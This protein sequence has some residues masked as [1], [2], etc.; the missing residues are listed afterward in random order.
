[1][2]DRPE[3]R[4][5]LLW[6]AMGTVCMAMVMAVMLALQMTQ[7]RA[8]RASSELQA[9]SVTALTFQLEREF[10]R[11][12]QTLDNA[13]HTDAPPDPEALTL[14]SDILMS[15]LH[16]MRD[17][18]STTILKDRREYV[19]ALPKL[20]A[21]MTRTT[22]VLATVPLDRR[23]LD[24]LLPEF[25][26]LGPDLQALSVASNSLLSDLL[27]Q[28]VR[29]MLDQND[30]IVWL[31]LAQLV[32]LLAAA[33]T[34]ALRQRRQDQERQKLEEMTREL[35]LANL[36]AQEANR[37]KSQFLANMSHE[38]RTPFNGMLGML[39]LLKDTQL[40]EQQTDFVSTAQASAGHLL[41][42]LNDILDVSAL[43]AGKMR[44]TPAPVHLPSLLMDVEALM[45]PVALEKNLGFTMVLPTELPQW[46]HADGTR[47]K[48]I[49]LN[50]LSNAIKFSSQGT[51]TLT[52][53]AGPAQAAATGLALI[54]L[55]VRVSDQGIGMD[56]QT[57]SRLFQR[58]SQG[59]AST[60]RRFGGT[61][62]GLEISRSL[63]RLMGGDISI[64]S[65]PGQG[66]VFTLALALP[67]S[68]PPAIAGTT[69]EP[70][71]RPA[72]SPGLD[73]LVAEDHPVNRKFME[74]LLKRL[75]HRARFA[76]NGAQAVTEA[77]R[78]V[79]DLILMDLHMPVMDGLQATRA[80]REGSDAA[81]S[82]PIVALTADAFH[83]SRDRTI[84][85]GM[86]GF[87]SKP[88]RTDQIEALLI[89][90]FGQRGATLPPAEST[91]P[92]PIA[93][94]APAPAPRR[95][96][97]AGD[98]GHHLDMSLVGEVCIAVSLS[99]YSNLLESFFR[100]EAQS[101]EQLAQALEAADKA[102]LKGLAHSVK[103]A[104]A[105]LGLQA[106]AQAASHIE[107]S[108]QEFNAGQCLQSRMELRELV[109]TAHAICHRMGLIGTP[110]PP[111]GPA[112][113]PP[114]PA[115]V[116]A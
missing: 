85:A 44:I 27:E 102:G 22:A 30:R 7:N 69:P 45:R 93:R 43:E 75:G 16:L 54:P 66:S 53:E 64:E 82:V 109:H 72:G 77:R 111:G 13:V 24:R 78:V 49:V 58:F 106:L 40:S 101:F 29:T 103:G 5:Y 76:E 92:A 59:D 47:I 116:P 61:G 28:Q 21:L 37:G 42:L 56:S 83:E 15:R 31:T 79:P 91:P 89:Q 98:V 57:Q 51:I 88:V 90:L 10:L 67:S 6:L 8:L 60:S 9:D 12:R 3:N 23:E 114:R 34:L 84:A 14:R 26:A 74:G 96:F 39:S 115:P 18:P 63:A 38:L 105:S 2:V 19:A 73:V 50:L 35:R 52:V 36:Q 33:A 86:N 112:T 11:M 46:I 95:R 99:G 71:Q 55:R 68:P 110:P 81:A 100:D 80:L 87:L 4:R 97:R 48:Q 25:I 94:P 107:T 70:A 104:A 62:L 41:T 20:D 17:N 1:V 108:G 113:S 65:A 32:M